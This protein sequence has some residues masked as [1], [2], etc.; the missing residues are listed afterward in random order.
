MTSETFLDLLN[1]TR[2]D[3]HAPVP[4]NLPS[5]PEN[6]VNNWALFLTN[7]VIIVVALV[8]NSITLFFIARHAEL[9]RSVTTSFVVSLACA[10]L[11]LASIYS[12]YNV[13]NYTTFTDDWESLRTPC[14]VSLY[15]IVLSAGVSNVSLA[16]VSI[17]RYIAVTRSL[18]YYSIVTRR[19]AHIAITLIWIYITAAGA[20]IFLVYGKNTIHFYDAPC[21][22]LNVVPEWY[23]FAILLPHML[24]PNIISKI[25]YARIA[26]V[27]QRQEARTFDQQLMVGNTHVK[28]EY[29]AAKT[30]ALIMV[31]FVV[32]WA[33]YFIIYT[34][35]F[36]T[37][38]ASDHWLF[39]AAELSKVLSVTS[40]CINPFIYAWKFDK[41]RKALRAGCCAPKK[42][43]LKPSSSYCRSTYSESR[44]MSVT[45]L[46]SDTSTTGVSFSGN[47]DDNQTTPADERGD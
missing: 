37:E 33:P 12:L 15:G 40:A 1:I 4:T 32:C 31:L 6:G 2:Q 10:D 17:D 28:R 43:Q 35:I 24:I 44:Q 41:F 25:V 11:L 19:R 23:F 26:C 8:G 20:S 39:T 21:S 9:R 29:R 30:M 5:S 18:R 45:S 46:Q 14:A 38:P 7:T 16:A 22:L 36:I 34:S 13:L 42:D 47:Q 27:A 3:G